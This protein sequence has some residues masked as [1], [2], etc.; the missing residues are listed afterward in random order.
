MSE[1]MPSPG[2]K[3]P[4]LWPLITCPGNSLSGPRAEA[5]RPLLERFTR[6]IKPPLT[7]HLLGKAAEPFGLDDLSPQEVEKHLLRHRF[8]RHKRLQW[9]DFIAAKGVETVV[10]KGM[11]TAHDIYP[12]P[13]FRHMSDM[14]LL[15]RRDDLAPLVALLKAEGFEFHFGSAQVAQ[16][17]AWCLITDA[18]FPPLI[19][20]EGDV[21]IDIHIHSPSQIIRA[22]RLDKPACLLIRKP[23]DAV[24]ALL[25][26]VPHFE[27]QDLLR[28]Y[29]LYYTSLLPFRAHFVTGLFD[30]VTAD[31][32]GVIRNLNKKFDTIYREIDQATHE[33][34]TATV[35][36]S[37]KVY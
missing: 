15:V 36:A 34:Y 2:A 35:P 23:E 32:C 5:L 11:A 22:T 14:D 28:A 26:K 20:R 24:T 30:D 13:D 17:P 18:S 3:G 16:V 4:G 29:H 25:V 10:L 33:G 27:C 37:R 6:R 19:S 7:T 9:A 1:S 21:N 12:D 31:F 8:L